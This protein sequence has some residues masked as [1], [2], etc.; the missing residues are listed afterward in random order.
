MEDH[1]IERIKRI[2]PPPSVIDCPQQTDRL[3]A[4]SEKVCMGVNGK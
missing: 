3:N 4:L 2:P 1:V